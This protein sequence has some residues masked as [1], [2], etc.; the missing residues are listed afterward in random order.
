MLGYGIARGPLECL[1]D[2]AAVD[3]LK[4]V[5]VNLLISAALAA[6]AVIGLGVLVS[7]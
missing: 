6:L 3:R 1:R 2:M 5:R 7:R 4:N